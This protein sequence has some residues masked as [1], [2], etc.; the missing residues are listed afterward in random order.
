MTDKPMPR[1]NTRKT[2]MRRI[3]E[4]GA[5]VILTSEYGMAQS[6]RE[7]SVAP[8]MME[9]FLRTM[10]PMISPDLACSCL[11]SI[12]LM[13]A[14]ELTEQDCV[15]QD[16]HMYTFHGD[17]YIRRYEYYI[18]HVQ[19]LAQDGPML[20]A[21]DSKPGLAGM[22]MLAAEVNA[23]HPSIRDGWTQINDAARQFRPA[24]ELT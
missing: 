11:L 14:V 6:A 22:T 8:D 10:R 23:R 21:R 12:M 13:R 20:L 17:V 24:E 16:E 19:Q 5:E 1:I 2:I 7:G 18:R 3:G 9:H 15:E 4:T